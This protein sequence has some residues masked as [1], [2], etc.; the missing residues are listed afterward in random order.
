MGVGG[1]GGEGGGNKGI[2]LSRGFPLLMATDGW[3]FY[4]SFLSRSPCCGSR[5]PDFSSVAGSKPWGGEGGLGTDAST[6]DREKETR[7]HTEKHSDRDAPSS[8]Q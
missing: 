8:S 5:Q 2:L 3:W 6:L 1:G 4:I 7:L